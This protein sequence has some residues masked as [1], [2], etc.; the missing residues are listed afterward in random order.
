VTT[1]PLKELGL[2][3]SDLKSEDL[4][5]LV[6]QLSDWFPTLKRVTAAQSQEVAAN[7]TA[8]TREYG[9]S[10]GND[11]STIISANITT[12]ATIVQAPTIALSNAPR[13]GVVSFRKD[14]LFKTA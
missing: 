11:C 13:F 12:I 8:V 6:S 1:H 3:E 14:Q 10:R 4:L 7:I 5:W 2:C 9:W